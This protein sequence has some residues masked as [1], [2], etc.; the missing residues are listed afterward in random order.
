MPPGLASRQAGIFS[1]IILEIG[2]SDPPA[3]WSLPDYCSYF[4]QFC[5][6]SKP[7]CKSSLL[8]LMWTHLPSS[9][10]STKPNNG[11]FLQLKIKKDLSLIHLLFRTPSK[12]SLLA[13]SNLAKLCL[14]TKRLVNIQHEN[15][16]GLCYCFTESILVTS[17]SFRLKYLFCVLFPIFHLFQ[18]KKK[19]LLH[20]E[21]YQVLILLYNASFNSQAIKLR[22]KGL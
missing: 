17:N 11:S 21:K 4:A 5:H 16:K 12:L 9:M 13:I 2:T 1:I 7:A 14:R 22:P 10:S 15:G 18:R 3:S 6:F 20:A 19:Y 8:H